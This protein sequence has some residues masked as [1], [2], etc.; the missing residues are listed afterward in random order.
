MALSKLFITQKKDLNDKKISI[1][2]QIISGRK[3]FASTGRPYLP[4]SALEMKLY[5][6][7]YVH[8]ID[9]LLDFIA[10]WFTKLNQYE[11][12]IMPLVRYLESNRFRIEYGINAKTSSSKL[13]ATKNRETNAGKLEKSSCR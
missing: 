6:C 2:S 8:H 10:L 5:L 1:F 12:L 4:S 9:G 7:C 3:T 13:L 11:R